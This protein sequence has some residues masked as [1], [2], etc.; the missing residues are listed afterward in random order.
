MNPSTASHRLVK[1]ILWELILQTEK[2]ICFKCKREMTRETF[3]IEHIIPW[4]DSPNPLELY[5]DQN[6]ISFT[7]LKC[8]TG[9]AR[10]HKAVCGTISKYSAGC[11]CNLCTFSVSE[12]KRK[13]LLI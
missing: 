4:L 11:R 6:N 8:N 9:D 7:H 13:K 1:D 3:S 2:N 12:N 10:K 5:F